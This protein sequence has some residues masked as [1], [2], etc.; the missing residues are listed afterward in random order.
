MPVISS[1]ALRRFL[2]QCHQ[3]HVLEVILAIAFKTL[4]N[5]TNHVAETPLDAPFAKNAWARPA[6]Q[7]A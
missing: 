4:S 2:G 1:G 3:Q 6:G 7:S 5:Y